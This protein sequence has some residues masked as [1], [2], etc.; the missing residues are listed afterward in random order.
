MS[1]APPAVRL[2]ADRAVGIP[3]AS[4]TAENVWLKL[5]ALLLA[6]ILFAL[7]AAAD[8]CTSGRRAAR[9]PGA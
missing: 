4:K 3:A 8:R 2:V 6:V 1:F 5:L 9:V 7:R